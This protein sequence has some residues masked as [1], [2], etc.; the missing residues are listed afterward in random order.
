MI[1]LEGV[2]ARSSSLIISIGAAALT[3]IL[4]A[5]PSS[6][7]AEPNTKNFCRATGQPC[8]LSVDPDIFHMPLP[9]EIVQSGDRQICATRSGPPTLPPENFG[10]DF[11]R[12]FWSTLNESDQTNVEGASY[13][14]I[15]T[16]WGPPAA[17]S[18]DLSGVA[19]PA[20][21]PDEVFTSLQSRTA[22]IEFEVPKSDFEK[23]G[24]QPAHLSIAIPPDPNPNVP[25][26]LRGWYIK[27][28]GVK[29]ERG[30]DGRGGGIQHPLIIMS[31]AFPYSI[32]DTGAV[33]G[34][35]VSRQM[36]KTITYLVASGYDV[37]F[38]DKRGHGYSEGL[39]DGMGE[40]VFRALD[41]LDRG[42]I[43]EDGV[44]LSLTITADG[45]TLQ[46]NA[47]AAERLLSAGYES[48]T[49]PVVFRGFSYGSSQL[50]KAMA[51]NYSNLPVEYR[52]KR[53]GSG[54]IVVDLARTPTG[55]RGYNFR[56]I[57]AISGFPGSV[58][59]ETIPY[60]LALDAGAST[61]GHNGSTLK[62]TVYQSMEKWPAF[63]GLY[64]TNDYETPDGPIDAFNNKLR[65]SKSI[66]M[67]TGYHFGL[68]SEEVDTYFAFETERF[69]RRAVFETAPVANLKTTTYT[70]QVCAAE[71]VTMDPS[72][73]S[74]SDVP[75][76]T[77][78]EANREVDQVIQMWLNGRR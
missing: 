70:E 15:T 12:D 69:A 64:A 66:K 17:P 40:D 4:A 26:K 74:I 73:Q 58:K 35:K 18:S 38:F 50:Q 9:G 67:I 57:V 22:R 60:F 71:Q 75:S 8:S 11:M 23:L 1:F 32:S 2:R 59:Y 77:I 5:A 49:K 37:L 56:G 24:W 76:K 3:A 46:G 6:V 45:R 48:K 29:A 72:T 54:Q 42:V 65:G 20:D 19:T 51:M 44:A 16:H 27:G 28:E 21:F 31:S 30:D 25:L 39:L 68:A 33:G 14:F 13:V 63:L 34:I 55:P 36:R 52:F 62:S 43:V 47:A 53:D 7:V 10:I 41:Q 61:Y 78:R